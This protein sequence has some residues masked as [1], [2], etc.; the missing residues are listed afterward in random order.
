MIANWSPSLWPNTG[1]WKDRSRAG[2]RIR[3]LVIRIR[4]EAM[5]P[6]GWVKPLPRDI[7]PYISPDGAGGRSP[8]AA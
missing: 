6:G 3:N 2:R 7:L 5:G 1:E 8:G 4:L